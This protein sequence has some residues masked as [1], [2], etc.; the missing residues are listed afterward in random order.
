MPE[1]S[2]DE[3][4]HL[5]KAHSNDARA[6]SAKKYMRDKFVFLGIPAPELKA[7]SK[8]FVGSAVRSSSID[9]IHDL[10]ERCWEKEERE[11]QYV[12][13]S[14]IQKSQKK[15][16]PATFELG[17]MLVTT[18]SWWDTVDSLAAHLFGP[19]LEKYPELLAGMDAFSVSSNFWER[20][21]AILHQLLARQRTDFARLSQYCLANADHPEFFIRKAIGWA[22]RTHARVN[23][24]DVKAFLVIYR[25]KFSSLSVREALKHHPGLY[26]E[27]ALHFGSNR[28]KQDPLRSPPRLAPD[29]MPVSS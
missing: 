14:L 6:S 3:L 11:F 18:K 15:W 8:D 27:L 26:A 13:C 28:A 29:R 22:L 25:E 9:Q 19:I 5:L 16:T 4:V 2:W 24:E 10:V 1:N 21:T 23:P 7:L 17:Q 12:G 20:R